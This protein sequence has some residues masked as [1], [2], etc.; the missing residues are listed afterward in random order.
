MHEEGEGALDYQAS[1]DPEVSAAM[2]ESPVAAFS[3][4]LFELEMVPMIRDLQLAL[5]PPPQPSQVLHRDEAGPESVEGVAV[6]LRIYQPAEQG[7]ARPCLYWM[8]G[9]GYMF[10]HPLMDEARNDRWVELFD[11]VVVAVD[12]RVAPEHPYPTPLEDCYAGLVWTVEHA[13]D[14]GIDPSSIVVGG[15]S[16]GGGLAAALALLA[17][18]RGE[19]DIVHQLLLYPML[20]DRNATYPST[21]IATPI[22]GQRPNLIGWRAYLGAEPGTA[23]L[24]PYVAAPRATDVTGLPSAFIAAGA[25]D[26]LRDEA[27]CYAS[28]LLE[29]G[30]Q[31]EL[32]VYPGAPHGFDV[33]APTAAVTQRFVRDVDD[34]LG[35]AFRLPGR[36]NTSASPT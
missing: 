4:D 9:G 19:V 36:D 15:L 16:A 21:R 2:A 1:V 7:T 5:V 35:R 28:R 25:L 3:W 29:A 24:P 11:C 20:D 12:Y 26:V 27:I 10:G 17:R 31:T 8:H 30:V 33:L 18:D 23:D 22:W 13:E 32:H 6:P 14:L 34:A